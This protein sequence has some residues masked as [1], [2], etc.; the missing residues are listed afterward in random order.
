MGVYDPLYIF[1]FTVLIGIIYLVVLFYT[2]YKTKF[3]VIGNILV[4]ISI[5]SYLLVGMYMIGAGYYADAGYYEDGYTGMLLGIGFLELI[6]LTYPY[7]FITLALLLG[8][9]ED[10]TKS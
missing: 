5:I 8:K 1:F 6:L 4:G 7:I 10:A 3:N 9:K 2:I